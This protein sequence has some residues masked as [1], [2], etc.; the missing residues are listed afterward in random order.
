METAIPGCSSPVKQGSHM[1]LR[2]RWTACWLFR[3]LR[4]LYSSLSIMFM[5]KAATAIHGN[6]IQHPSQICIFPSQWT[7]CH[8][9]LNTHVRFMTQRQRSSPAHALNPHLSP[10]LILPVVWQLHLLFLMTS[11]PMYRRHEHQHSCHLTNFYHNIANPWVFW[12]FFSVFF[13]Q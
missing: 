4:V 5:I 9:C 8:V 6:C 13:S 2:A 11:P 3:S 10:S 12:G 1:P 7:W